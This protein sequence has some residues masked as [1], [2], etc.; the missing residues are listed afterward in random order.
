MFKKSTFLVV[1]SSALILL[2]GF[3]FAYRRCLSDVCK[4]EHKI[5]HS[6][7][8]KRVKAVD[9]VWPIVI[10]GS[11]PAALS[12]ALYAA[13]ANIDTLVIEGPKPGGLLVDTTEVENWPGEVSIMGPKLMSAMKYQVS[14]F[15]VQFMANTV[16]SVDFHSWPYKIVLEDG[17]YQH[18]LTVVVATGATPKKLDVTGESSYWGLGVTSCATC[19]APFFK[20]ED[21]VVVGGG[22]SAIEEALQLAKHVH[23]V[24]ILVRKDRMRA[25]ARMQD[26]L[27]GYKN[28]SVR[29][30]LEIQ[31]ILGNNKQV[32]G[33]RLLNHTTGQIEE[34]PTSGVFLAIG[35]DPS[36]RVFRG[37]LD[38]CP[39]GHIKMFDRTQATSV[40]GVFAA[41]DV[42]DNRYR[43]AIVAAGHGVSAALDAIGFLQEIG[44][45]QAIS[46]YVHAHR[47]KIISTT[48]KSRVI[49]VASLAQ[50][51]EVLASSKVVVADFFTDSCSSCMHMMPAYE[52]VSTNFQD[53]TFVKIDA[54][55]ADDILATHMVHK[56]PYLL[57]FKDGAVVARFKDTM[58]KKE[59]HEFVAQFA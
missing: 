50:F 14:R 26:R 9:N 28:I 17:T 16:D 20:G 40:A 19:D 59:L 49:N 15:D 6:V 51:D 48:A 21:V 8:I 29:Y 32:T 42:E 36:S 23:H 41:G 55:Q 24:T 54:A 57:V 1:I 45:D 33:V 38:M 31:E 35:H 12:A 52:E 22:D 47:T 46:E 5:T 3:A 37:Q 11:G 13:R 44:F 25:A 4:M 30:N 39:M 2:V 34:M 27:A 10:I 18:A 7:D 53:V 56:V 58:N 43:Q